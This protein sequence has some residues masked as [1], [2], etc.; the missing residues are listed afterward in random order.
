VEHGCDAPFS[1]ELIDTLVDPTQPMVERHVVRAVVLQD[2]KL[3]VVFPADERIYGTPGGGI[4][5]GET[6]EDAL[7]RELKEEVGADEIVI[8]SH[9]G[10][11]STLRQHPD[12][13]QQ[14]RPVHHL[15]RVDIKRFGEATLDDYEASLGLSWAFVDP[16]EVIQTNEQRLRERF[17][18]HL[19]FYS[20]QTV[21]LEYL[22]RNGHLA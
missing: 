16:D 11:M 6:H 12:L 21:L 10:T 19:D 22:K 15:Y 5:P 17:T 1:I 7:R 4:R 14:F 13:A 20:N 18:G 3:L 2:G 9:L 8:R